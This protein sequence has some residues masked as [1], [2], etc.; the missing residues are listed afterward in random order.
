MEPA[1]KRGLAVSVV[2]GESVPAGLLLAP[3]R[4]EELSTE[5]SFGLSWLAN[6][7]DE[8]ALEALGSSGLED[9]KENEVVEGFGVASPPVLDA[10]VSVVP[11]EKEGVAGLAVASALGLAWNSED[12]D[13][14][15]VGFGAK[16]A[17]GVDFA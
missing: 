12:A 13:E 1:P 8:G 9:P 17:N 11:K 5:D 7:L 16:P 3:K 14:D 10:A 2:A 4:V 6:K 15:S